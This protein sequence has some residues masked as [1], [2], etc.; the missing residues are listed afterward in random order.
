[1]ILLRFAGHPGSGEPR[2][3]LAVIHQH[4]SKVRA[5]SG[6]YGSTNATQSRYCDR[7]AWRK[8]NVKIENENQS[9][10]LKKL[11]AR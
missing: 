11:D 2:L 1:M 4:Q 5:R 3:R 10:D 6:C 7:A 8:R 9:E